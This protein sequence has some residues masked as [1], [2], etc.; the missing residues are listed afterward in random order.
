M[1]RGTN[2][3]AVDAMG[4]LV[5]EITQEAFGYEQVIATHYCNQPLQ[6]V[7]A[8]GHCNKVLEQFIA[9][10][11]LIESSFLNWQAFLALDS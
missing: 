6:Q 7:I 3:S 1:R 10:S 2:V 5:F 8:T 11:R 9:I 4:H